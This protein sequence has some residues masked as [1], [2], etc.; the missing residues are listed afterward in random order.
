[1]PVD[2]LLAPHDLRFPHFERLLDDLLDRV[3]VVKVDIFELVHRRLDIAR[4][5]E[6][7]NEKWTPA[8]VAHERLDF[9]HRNDRVGSC[10][11]TDQNIHLLKGGVPVLEMDR[12][13]ANLVG[14]LRSPVKRPVGNDHRAHAARDQAARGSLAR[15]PGPEK[16]HFAAG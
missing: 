12:H 6:V 15:V 14:E 3:D 16:H 7:D 11:R 1:M 5:S 2:H 8:A 10:C 9:F 13:A 4:N